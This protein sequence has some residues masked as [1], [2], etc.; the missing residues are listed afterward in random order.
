MDIS[1]FV[2]YITFHAFPVLA[3]Y[4]FPF[5]FLDL[6]LSFVLKKTYLRQKNAMEGLKLFGSVATAPVRAG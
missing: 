6:D 2:G 1:C 4:A 3:S 5:L